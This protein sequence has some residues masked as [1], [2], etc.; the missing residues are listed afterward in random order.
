METALYIIIIVVLFILGV[1]VLPQMMLRR[2]IKQVVAIFRNNGATTKSSAKLL[3]EMGIKQ[4]GM[5][6]L[7]FGL[8]DYKPYAAQALLKY[9]V[10]EQTEEGKLYLNESKTHMLR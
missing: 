3:E 7:R 6:S 1:V 8:R 9:G 4:Q 2:A 5:F 10:L